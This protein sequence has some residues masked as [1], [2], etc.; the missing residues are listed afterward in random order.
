MICEDVEISMDAAKTR[1]RKAQGEISVGEILL[2][3]SG[4]NPLEKD[5][6]PKLKAT[7]SQHI[8]TLFKANIGES[9]IFAVELKIV[10]TGVVHRKLLRLKDKGSN[11]G[12]NRLAGMYSDEDS[13]EKTSV[14]EDLVLT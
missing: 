2:P 12:D 14:D 8:A 6:K 10:T 11:V 5:V 3:S 1:E 4:I 9:S 7:S 13:D